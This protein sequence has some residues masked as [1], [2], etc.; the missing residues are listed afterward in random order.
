LGPRSFLSRA[1][2]PL[3]V[4]ALVL[5]AAGTPLVSPALT[6]DGPALRDAIDRQIHLD[7]QRLFDV[8]G[9]RVPRARIQPRLV[10]LYHARDMA[11]FWVSP[12]GPNLNAAVLRAVLAEADGHGLNPDDYSVGTI[13][14]YWARRDAPTT[15][16]LELLLTLALG[17]Y[18]SDLAEGRRKPREFDQKLFPTACDCDLD[19][20]ALVMK[21]MAAA[22]LRSFLEDQA[23]PFRQYREL[24]AKLA[25]Y[26]AFAAGGGWPEV[27]AGPS[28]KP[29]ARDPRVA[30]V[31][32]RLDVTDGPALGDPA[33]E[34]VYDEALV[35]AVKK[36]QRRHG[37][38]PDGVIGRGTVEAMNVPAA[39]RVKQI[40][41]NM[42]SW[43]W[44]SPAGGDRMLV[45]NIPAFE[46]DALR[47]DKAE[48]SMPV[49]V[50]E[51]YHMTPV[52]SDR[53]RYIEVNP[54]WDVPQSIAAKEMLPKLRQDPQY[55]KKQRIRM[56]QGDPSKPEIDSAAVA[57]NKVSPGDMDRYWLRQDPGPENSLGTLAFM[58]PNEF[59]V[60]LHD[61]PARSLFDREKRA[62]SHG[63]IRVARAK[64]LAIYVLGG[65]DKGWDEDRIKAL[66]ATG[67]NG[68]VHVDPPLP[69][70][71]LYNT[72][73]VDPGSHD[74][75]FYVDVYGRDALLERAI[76]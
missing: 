36:F 29:G 70:Y 48:L 62:F 3:T 4:A 47:D 28:L 55:L 46:L 19:P 24:R 26:R 11:P 56:F 33:A 12:Q 5:A 73:V 76:F 6:E 60:Y 22:D 40:I 21:S 18:V 13:D 54:Y 1:A 8:P 51:E 49:I 64:D 65:A 43:R 37:L 39:A 57:W 23:P 15:A 42:E 45:I 63:C 9:E 67:T 30:A 58:F 31:R 20:A 69:V 66:I 72:A 17:D 71:I 2:G 32:Q 41:V 14:R 44:V 27:P 74:I 61:T 35:A 52:F 10:Q 59:S 53:L 16:R 38:E 75:R 25:E 68:I 50:G 7:V 34:T